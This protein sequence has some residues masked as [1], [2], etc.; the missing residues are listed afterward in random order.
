MQT[1]PEKISSSTFEPSKQTAIPMPYHKIFK[2]ETSSSSKAENVVKSESRSMSPPASQGIVVDLNKLC[3][4]STASDNRASE[5]E[6]KSASEKSFSAV[7]ENKL[8]EI[9]EVAGEISSSTLANGNS[10]N[11]EEPD[12]RSMNANMFLA[13]AT[14]E[15]NWN[16]EKSEGDDNSKEC[17]ERTDQD[18][19]KADKEE[20]SKDENGDKQT[21]KVCRH[22][23]LKEPRRK[24]FKKCQK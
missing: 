16:E 23:G 3:L 21:L 10:C 19:E 20:K 6:V 5:N 11:L 7:T 14:K 22:C 17:D 24:A 4:V 1:S 12:D 18:A 8:G 15:M 9:C 13:S 2:E